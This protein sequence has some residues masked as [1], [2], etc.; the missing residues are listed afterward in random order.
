M[1]T[2][3]DGV[4]VD[5]YNLISNLSINIGFDEMDML[6]IK[7]S[8]CTFTAHNKCHQF[9]L[10]AEAKRFI[11]PSNTFFVY[12]LKVKNY[13]VDCCLLMCL[14]FWLSFTFIPYV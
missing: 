5:A 4:S 11:D 12:Y 14:F 7:L 6:A 3:G 8:D 13:L 2:G 10:K 1:D 9:L